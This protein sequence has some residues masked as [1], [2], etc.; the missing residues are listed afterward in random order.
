M[1][2]I[3][4][5][6]RSARLSHCSR[7]ALTT[8][9]STA[10]VRRVTERTHEQRHVILLGIAN[11]KHDFDERMEGRDA[12][13]RE[14]RSRIEAQAVRTGGGLSVARPQN[15][16]APPGVAARG[17]GLRPTPPPAA[18]PRDRDAPP[19]PPPRGVPGVGRDPP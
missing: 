1:P 11:L 10:A 9:G 7:C 13:G 8:T 2:V 14:V 3:T 6:Q 4:W 5:A 15:C 12:Q 19:P 17:G 18:R 16:Y